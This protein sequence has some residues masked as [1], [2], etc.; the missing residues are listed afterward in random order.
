MRVLK[1]KNGLSWYEEIEATDGTRSAEV[2]ERTADG[3]GTPVEP[4]GLRP[5]P[6]DQRADKANHCSECRGL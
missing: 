2:V 3:N 4:S 1:T 5:D 6:E